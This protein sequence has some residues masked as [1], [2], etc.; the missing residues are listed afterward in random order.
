MLVKNPI[1]DQQPKRGTNGGGRI[2][3]AGFSEQALKEILS[4]STHFRRLPLFGCV[5]KLPSRFKHPTKRPKRT[6]RFLDMWATHGGV[7][8][9]DVSS[10]AGFILCATKA[11]AYLPRRRLRGGVPFR[12][13]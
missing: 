11:V 13:L 10:P 1:I 2:P 5:R 3:N 9:N 7:A 8:S 6:S 4:L 12:S